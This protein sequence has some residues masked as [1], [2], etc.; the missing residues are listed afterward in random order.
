MGHIVMGNLLRP[1]HNGPYDHAEF[2]AS[3]VRGYYKRNR[4]FQRYVVSKSLA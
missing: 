2:V 4:H 1:L 3:A